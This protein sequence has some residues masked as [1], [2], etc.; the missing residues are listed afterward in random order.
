M[1]VSV[2]TG[3]SHVKRRE[4]L[5]FFCGRVVIRPFHKNKKENT[6]N[7]RADHHKFKLAEKVQNDF[8]VN[9]DQDHLGRYC[10]ERGHSDDQDKLPLR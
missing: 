8:S 5:G 6:N 7:C 9:A 2:A 3:R 10:E 4:A 1:Q